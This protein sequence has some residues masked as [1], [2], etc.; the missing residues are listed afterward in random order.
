MRNAD[1]R[2]WSLVVDIMYQEQEKKTP[3]GKFRIKQRKMN[4]YTLL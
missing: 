3:T 4:I 2:M 1:D